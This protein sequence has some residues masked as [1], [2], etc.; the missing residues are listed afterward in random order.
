[1][2]RK[3]SPTSTVSEAACRIGARRQL[4]FG[5]GEITQR[6]PEVPAMM[7][8]GC[9]DDERRRRARDLGAAEFFSQPV[10]LDFLEEQLRQLPS[11]PD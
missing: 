1:M 6:F 10:D 7:V 4:G 11:T 2:E 3:R 5:V 8:A 9:G